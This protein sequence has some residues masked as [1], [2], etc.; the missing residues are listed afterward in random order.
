[1]LC[2]LFPGS[3]RKDKAKP[4]SDRQKGQTPLNSPSIIKY[5]PRIELNYVIHGFLTSPKE[6]DRLGIGDRKKLPHQGQSSTSW[7]PTTS[8][9]NFGSW[10]LHC[11]ALFDPCAVYNITTM[12]RQGLQLARN[13]VVVRAGSLPRRTACV[14]AALDGSGTATT[15]T[16][17]RQSLSNSAVSQRSAMSST[18]R[19][20]TCTSAVPSFQL[21]HSSSTP[22]SS[23]SSSSPTPPPP[24]R[25]NSHPNLF[26]HC[27]PIPDDNTLALSYLEDSPVLSTSGETIVSA[28]V[29]G[30]LPMDPEA[31]LNDFV[32]NRPFR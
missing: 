15:A 4:A 23:S 7:I 29:L 25:D 10:S 26:Y 31:G 18:W 11:V 16:T 30:F 3:R 14:V 9:W 28:T 20:R 12:N 22:A 19:K 13:S 32:E 21:R 1:M 6:I 27:L 17:G 2:L 8:S 5:K 24:T